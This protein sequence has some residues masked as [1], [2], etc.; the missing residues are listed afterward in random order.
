MACGVPVV[1]ATGGVSARIIEESGIGMAVPCGDKQAMI[2]AINRMLDETDFHQQCSQSARH[3]AE[4]NYDPM[5][6]AIR[7]EEVLEEAVRSAATH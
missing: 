7:Y 6:V 5:Q 1:A 2:G 3:Y 4:Q